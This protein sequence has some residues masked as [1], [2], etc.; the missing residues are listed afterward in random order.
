MNA[1][2]AA[3]THCSSG[4]VSVGNALE[5]FCGEDLARV[6]RRAAKL[7]TD[8]TC[9]IDDLPTLLAHAVEELRAEGKL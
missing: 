3:P 4:L 6:L 7:A 2:Q 9:I 1:T 8:P 5:R